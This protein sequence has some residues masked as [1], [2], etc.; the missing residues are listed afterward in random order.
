[1]PVC[2]ELEGGLSVPR[3]AAEIEPGGSG[4]AV[5]GGGARVLT[6]TGAD[7]SGAFRLGAT[8]ALSAARAGDCRY[9]LLKENSPSCG[10]SFVHAG[11][12]DGT[13]AAGEGVTARLLRNN[14]IA[15]FS[16]HQIDELASLL[17]DG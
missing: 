9:A 10:S 2:P 7:V 13:K 1:M 16:E 17:G 14:G 15:V 5:L 8:S 11:R 3:P 6:K 4:E 12:F